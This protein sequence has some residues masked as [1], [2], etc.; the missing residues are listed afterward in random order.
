[1]TCDFCPNPALENCKIK[2]DGNPLNTC[3]EHTRKIMVELNYDVDKFLKEYNL[4]MNDN[5]WNIDFMTSDLKNTAKPTIKTRI[6]STK[7]I[8]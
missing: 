5:K 2:N 6:E 7:N 8:L 1:M 3:E 4:T